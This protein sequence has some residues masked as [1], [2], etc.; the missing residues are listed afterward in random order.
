MAFERENTSSGKVQSAAGSVKESGA[1]TVA[2]VLGNSSHPS[3]P[4]AGGKS[5]M[6]V[7]IPNVRDQ[8]K[9]R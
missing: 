6:Q 9:I 8:S 5:G 1:H 7:K 3:S 4:G 2:R